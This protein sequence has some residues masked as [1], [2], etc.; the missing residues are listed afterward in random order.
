MRRNHVAQSHLLGAGKDVRV[1]SHLVLLARLDGGIHG[2][3]S[4]LAQK[5]AWKTGFQI[6][7]A[8][9]FGDVAGGYS[10]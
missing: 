8:Y 2:C 6:E 10:E 4:G 7:L 9:G 1:Q 5:R 3:K